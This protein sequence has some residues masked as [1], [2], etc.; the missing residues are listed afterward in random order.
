MLIRRYFAASR[1]ASAS[2]EFALIA[3]FLLLPL[4]LGS[5]DFLSVLSAQSQLNTALQ[6]LYYFA[7]TSPTSANNATYAGYVI[8]LINNRSIFT[9]TLPATLPSG[10]AN[11]SLSYSCFTPPSTVITY[12]STT[13][14]ATQT[15][16]TLVSYQVK[17]VITLPFPFFGLPNPMTLSAA[18]KAQIQ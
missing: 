11:A 14:S 2:V 18:G 9:I 8:S 10:A 7:Y 12:Q 13:C 15:Q 4:A 5:A 6:S 17:T 16:Q 1:S 3:S